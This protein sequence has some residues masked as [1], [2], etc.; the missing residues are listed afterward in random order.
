MRTHGQ[1]QQLAYQAQVEAEGGRVR[2][3]PR[4]TKTSPASTLNNVPRSGSPSSSTADGISSSLNPLLANFA[5]A[6]A[7]TNV[8]NSFSALNGSKLGDLGDLHANKQPHQSLL[9]SKQ[10]P[11]SSSQSTNTTQSP[12]YDLFGQTGTVQQL[13]AVMAAAGQVS[14]VP[15]PPPFFAN[16]PTAAA[17]LA[18]GGDSHNNRLTSQTS[19]GQTATS[20]LSPDQAATAAAA[21]AAAAGGNPAA[22]A[23]LLGIYDLNLGEFGAEKLSL[24][25]RSMYEEAGRTLANQSQ[26]KTSKFECEKCDRWFNSQAMLQMHLATH[27]LQTSCRLC[28]LELGSPEVYLA[29]CQLKH[30]NLI[31]S[32]LLDVSEHLETLTKGMAL[33]TLPF[34]NPLLGL[35][36]T[37]L[38]SSNDAINQVSGDLLPNSFGNKKLSSLVRDNSILSNSLFGG[39]SNFS[40]LGK[41]NF[42][43]LLQLQNRDDKLSEVEESDS[44]LFKSTDDDIRDSRSDEEDD[45]K[46]GSDDPKPPTSNDDELIDTKDKPDNHKNRKQKEEPFHRHVRNPRSAPVTTN[47][48]SSSSTCKQS[49]LADI[50]S[51]ISVINNATPLLG[52]PRADQ[53]TLAQL[54]QLAQPAASALAEN[55]A[56]NAIANGGQQLNRKSPPAASRASPTPANSPEES[57]APNAAST[58]IRRK[59]KHSELLDSSL[60]GATCSSSTASTNSDH[61]DQMNGETED[62]QEDRLVR[63]VRPVSSDSNNNQQS[64]KSV[65]PTSTNQEAANEIIDA[66][67]TAA[68]AAAAA[69]EENRLLEIQLQEQQY[70]CKICKLEV[71]SVNTLRRHQRLHEQGGHLFS[72]HYCPYTSLDKSSLIRHLRTHNGERP[73]QCTICKYAFTTK[74]N[75]ERHVRK[76]HKLHNR[77]DYKQRMQTTG[78]GTGFTTT[79]RHPPQ[80]SPASMVSI[81]HQY[82]EP[83]AGETTCKYCSVDFKFNRL[84]RQHLRTMC[85]NNFAKKPFACAVCKLGF[86]SRNNCARHVLKTHPEIGQQRLTE[87]LLEQFE[88]P[89][90]GDQGLNGSNGGG[91]SCNTS[92][93]SSAASQASNGVGGS[94]VTSDEHSESESLYTGDDLGLSTSLLSTGLSSPSQLNSSGN[95]SLPTVGSSLEALCKIAGLAE[96]NQMNSSSLHKRRS[97]PP[98][99][100]RKSDRPLS[101]DEEAEDEIELDEELDQDAEDRLLA[102]EMFNEKEH[103]DKSAHKSLSESTD[104]SALDL[105]VKSNG[106]ASDSAISMSGSSPI[107]AANM[108]A[109][110]MNGGGGLS[111]M[112]KPNNEPS[113]DL[114]YNALSSLLALQSF[115]PKDHPNDLNGNNTVNSMTNGVASDLMS[116]LFAQQQQQQLF[117]MQQLAA[118]AATAAQMPNSFNEALY[119]LGGLSSFDKGLASLPSGNGLA[120]LLL[121]QSAQLSHNQFSARSPA[122][123]IDSSGRSVRSSLNC[124]FCPAMFTLKPHLDRHLKNKHPEAASVAGF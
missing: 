99:N 110:S 80:N 86:T 62:E 94:S 102:E 69:E 88:Q 46:S 95:R 4:R 61:I 120:G 106:N 109:S 18:V 101:E 25:T 71:R 67:A 108:T 33:N 105:S 36:R 43:S 27:Q 77:T 59:R 5:D 79:V 54:R 51:I 112:A 1:E 31:L 104:P 11:I 74:A 124:Q 10:T 23:A 122:S 52:S 6:E 81:P 45:H 78:K 116:S 8:L 111:S 118:A 70:L 44:K 117:G 89:A 22:A 63:P 58:P 57:R 84:L 49:D 113:T 76:R 28:D 60:N 98:A 85:N 56:L 41:D 29:H 37:S 96:Q 65:H 55:S 24:L 119:A 15:A 30:M 35:S 93:L 91:S 107:S 21:A 103:H 114:I 72:C 16:L 82:Y 47:G 90:G 115:A 87:V 26:N 68:A 40:K 19:A 53:R 14:A 17:A 13:A 7:L 100:G 121:P 34:A 38:H 39:V 83:P 123:S 42:L 92:Q 73:Y 50:Q 3:K 66:A 48:S 12:L 9:S 64:L 20:A 75:C 2:K 97:A 32:G